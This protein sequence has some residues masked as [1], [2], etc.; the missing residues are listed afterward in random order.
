M[1]AVI[2]ERGT[3][4]RQL[5]AEA[6]ELAELRSAEALR[7]GDDVERLEQVRLALP[8]VSDEDVEPLARLELQRAEVTDPGRR[9]DL[10]PQAARSSWA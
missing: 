1:L 4:A 10:E 2:G 8:V 6:H 7:R 3:H 5:R 9:E